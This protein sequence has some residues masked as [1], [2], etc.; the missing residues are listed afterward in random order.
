M[1][2]HK[3]VLFR[4]LILCFFLVTAIL[5]IK[6][7]PV[8]AFSVSDYFTLNYNVTLNTS[9][10]NEGQTF[11]AIASGVATCK[12]ELPISV[13]KGIIDSRIVATNQATGAEVTLNSGY[14]VT[15]S[16][17][18]NKVGQILQLTQTIP[19]NF[20]AGSPAG[21]Y[22]V[23]GEL[24][25]AKVNAII[26][27]DV[28]D[29]FPASQTIGVVNY[30]SSSTGGGGGGT[31][32]AATT[33][34]T[35]TTPTTAIT[36]TM[37]TNTKL[38]TTTPASVPIIISP[39]VVNVSPMVNSQGIFTQ[40]VTLTSADGL[41]SLSI[42]SGTM[43]PTANGTL[44]EQISI[45]PVTSPPAPPPGGDFIGLAYDFEPSG[46]TFNPSISMKFTYNPANIPSGVSENS[47]VVTF[48]STSTGQWVAVPAVVDS[49]SYTITAQVS[50]FT[51][52]S[53]MYIPVTTS[54]SISTTTSVLKATSTTVTTRTPQTKLSNEWIAA[55]VIIITIVIVIVLLTLVTT[56]RRKK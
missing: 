54:T 43:G 9:D 20:P 19:L 24:I 52:Y 22:N 27:I 34:T 44:L 18:P 42:P 36:T 50:H 5:L 31:I 33:P 46:A 25:S 23:M 12:A 40:S 11:N 15:I 14:E 45:L 2:L 55:I 29:N 30:S 47:L 7:Q 49:V 35:T 38:T 17:F 10:V 16:P 26:W 3:A 28:S 41:V 4:N 53:V 13:S 37:T 1:N 32:T 6:I 56:V 39:G 48:Y 51:I 21:S 8:A